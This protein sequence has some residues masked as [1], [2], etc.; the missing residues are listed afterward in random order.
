MSYFIIYKYNHKTT[1]KLLL[2]TI[3]QF[4]VWLPRLNTLLQNQGLVESS[5][6]VYGSKHSNEVYCL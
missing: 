1:I 5:T 6:A 3:F 4:V 2:I